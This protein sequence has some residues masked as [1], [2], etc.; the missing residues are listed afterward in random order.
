[1]IRIRNNRNERKGKEYRGTPGDIPGDTLN[2][3]GGE[4]ECHYL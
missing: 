4:R 1:M 3:T 2:K